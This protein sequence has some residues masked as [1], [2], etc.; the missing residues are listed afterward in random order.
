MLR[1]A[2]FS[3]RAAVLPLILK[4][5]EHLAVLG[6]ECHSITMTG[7]DGDAECPMERIVGH[8]HAR[9]R[10]QHHFL[11]AEHRGVCHRLFYTQRTRPRG[12]TREEAQHF[13]VA[14]AKLLAQIRPDIVL[15]T[16]VD[17]LS[18]N[19]HEAT[20]RVRAIVVFYLANPA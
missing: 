10:Y 7:F 13:A 11:E 18:E 5:L 15:T 1:P 8:E 3:T 17:A 6:F 14:T 16:G 4:R 19:L 2:T 9:A 12:L 20:R